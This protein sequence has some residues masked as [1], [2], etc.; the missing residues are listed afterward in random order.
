M[1]VLV[2]P[3]DGRGGG[4]VVLEELLARLSREY[5]GTLALLMSEKGSAAIRVPS[6][7]IQLRSDADLKELARDRNEIVRVVANANR[8]FPHVVRARE[9]LRRRGIRAEALAVV[10]GQVAVPTGGQ[11][12][13]PTLRGEFSWS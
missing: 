5:T 12:K 10:N 4:Q 8:S 11:L 13:V 3:K 2:D 1:I 9:M 6:N 7:V